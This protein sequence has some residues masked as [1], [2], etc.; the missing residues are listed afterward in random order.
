MITLQ[1]SCLAIVLLSLGIGLARAESRATYLRQYSLLVVA[2]W[3]AEDSCIRLYG[4]Y[5]YAPDW[6]LFVDRVP[7]LVVLI[8]PCVIQSAREL[9]GAPLLGAAIVLTDAALI[10]PIAVRAKLWAWTEPGLFGVPPIGILGWALFAGF[11]LWLLEHR[12]RLMLL[13]APP[14]THAALLALWWCA[15]RWVNHPLPERLLVGLVWGVALLLAWRLRAVRVDRVALLARAPGAVF[16]FVL[17]AS[18]GGN[19][20]WL[21]P[22]SLAFASPYLVLVFARRNRVC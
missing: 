16:F 7:L 10:E 4:F 2:A 14:L 6:W 3:I 9:A 17:L 20:P 15:L 18:Y 19:S 11:A 8:W 12:E 1:L 21:V 5:H 13:L 22:Y